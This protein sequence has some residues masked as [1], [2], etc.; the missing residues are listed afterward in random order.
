VSQLP[1]LIL[2]SIERINKKQTAFEWHPISVYSPF[3]FF[4][5]LIQSRQI[6]LKN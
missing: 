5:D 3:N 4:P 6:Y 2:N 1:L